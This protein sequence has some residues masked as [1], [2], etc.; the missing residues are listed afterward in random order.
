MQSCLDDDT[1]CKVFI[2]HFVFYQKHYHIEIRK[3]I[4]KIWLYDWIKCF[5][6]EQLCFLLCNR[7]ICLK[8]FLFLITHI[9]TLSSYLGISSHNP[10]FSFY[11]LTTSMVATIRSSLTLW[12]PRLQHDPI[13]YGLQ[14][15]AGFLLDE[16]LYKSEDLRHNFNKTGQW[17]VFLYTE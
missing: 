3:I 11:C 4:N 14:A 8:I 12:W 1:L 2:V 10:V 13:I 16:F 15:I 17:I 6:V 5:P 7:N 9:L